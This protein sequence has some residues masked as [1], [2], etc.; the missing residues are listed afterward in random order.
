MAPRKRAVPSMMSCLTVRFTSAP[1]P[2]HT[3][4]PC[5][6]GPNSQKARK[7]EALTAVM[8][9]ATVG[10]VGQVAQSASR[11]VRKYMVFEDLKWLPALSECTCSAKK[12][13][14]PK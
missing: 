13:S 8:A 2:S 14:R 10:P 6:G 12:R 3:P 1:S 11:V 7:A 5:P 4:L 9:V